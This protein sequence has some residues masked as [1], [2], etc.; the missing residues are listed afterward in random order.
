MME[1]TTM[2]SRVYP[3]SVHENHFPTKPD[4][5]EGKKT[6]GTKVVKTFLRNSTP[7]KEEGEGRK[8][9]WRSRGR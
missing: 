7:E 5:E 6:R 9:G 2:L 3:L 4:D 8:R 1:M